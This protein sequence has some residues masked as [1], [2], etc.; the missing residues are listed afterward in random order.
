[1][2]ACQRAGCTGHYAD[3]GY[4]DECGRKAPAGFV[5]SQAVASQSMPSGHLAA[6]SASASFGTAS[7]GTTTSGGT[8]RS[9]GSSRR[10]RLGANLVAM[11]PVRHRRNAK[12]S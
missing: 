3:D 5:P 8:S 4:C 9:R 12:I 1:M 6:T 2:I 10:G 7:F 11:P